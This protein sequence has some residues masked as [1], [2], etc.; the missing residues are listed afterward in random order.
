MCWGIRRWKRSFCTQRIMRSEQGIL[1]GMY[2]W[3]RREIPRLMILRCFDIPTHIWP[4]PRRLLFFFFSD[5][6]RVPLWSRHF[7]VIY[8]FKLPL[9][10]LQRS[11]SNTHIKKHFKKFLSNCIC[12]FLYCLFVGCHCSGEKKHP[13][14]ATLSSLWCTLLYALHHKHKKQ[15]A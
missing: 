15:A 9:C 1:V 13:L 8:L 2:G 5:V 14:T 12:S 3:M 7:L 11:S 6:I 10:S 4:R